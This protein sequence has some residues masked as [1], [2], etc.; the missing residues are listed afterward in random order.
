[1]AKDVNPGEIETVLLNLEGDPTAF[2][3]FIAEKIGPP[4][5]GP[6]PKEETEE[7]GRQPVSF[8]RN[9]NCHHRPHRLHHR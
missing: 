4:L 5:V 9:K 6:I 3:R 2:A 1:V 8:H 7:N